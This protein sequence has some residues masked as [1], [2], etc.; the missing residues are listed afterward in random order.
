MMGILTLYVSYIEKGIFIV[1]IQRDPTG[2]SPDIIW[3]ASSTLEK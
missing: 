1:I 3:G 2:F